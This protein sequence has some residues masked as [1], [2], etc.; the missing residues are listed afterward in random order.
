MIFDSVEQKEMTLIAIS[1]WAVPLGQAAQALQIAQ[2]IQA[3]EVIP[4]EKVDKS[5]KTN[6]PKKGTKNA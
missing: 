6:K 4:P 2:S 3:G 5:K 1:K